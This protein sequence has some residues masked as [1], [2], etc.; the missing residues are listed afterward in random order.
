MTLVIAIENPRGENAPMRKY[1][2]LRHKEKAILIFLAKQTSRQVD[3]ALG[4][5][6]ILQKVGFD[7]SVMENPEWNPHRTGILVGIRE[8]EELE[9][10]GWLT[11]HWGTFTGSQEKTYVAHLT[12]TNKA[13]LAV[14]RQ[15]GSNKSVALSEEEN[16]LISVTYAFSDRQWPFQP[17]GHGDWLIT[18][19]SPSR[20]IALFPLVTQKGYTFEDRERRGWRLTEVGLALAEEMEENPE[21]VHH[22]LIIMGDIKQNIGSGNFYDN[23]NANNLAIQTQTKDSTQTATQTAGVAAGDLAALLKT[24]REQLAGVDDPKIKQDAE[25][26]LAAIEEEAAKKQ[27]NTGRIKAYAAQAIRTVA[28]VTGFARSVIEICKTTGVDL[29]S[30]IQH[31]P[32]E[33]HHLLQ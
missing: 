33:L 11:I 14:H 7:G 15:F 13:C 2:E 12:P 19:L 26:S 21:L 8:L 1:P 29:P 23:Q 5:D 22:R 6:A 17:G 18:F 20:M 9:N 16:A 28:G 4:I 3:F 30:L 31:I 32:A 10:K 25:D 24:A 27:P